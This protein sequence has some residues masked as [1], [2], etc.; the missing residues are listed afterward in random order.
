MTDKGGAGR[1]WSDTKMQGIL[2]LVQVQDVG[3][4]IINVRLSGTDPAGAERGIILEYELPTNF[5]FTADLTSTFSALQIQQGEFL[6]FLF[7]N[8]SDRQQFNNELFNIKKQLRLS[9]QQ[10]ADLKKK[11]KNKM[12]EEFSNQLADSI[13]VDELLSG[14]NIEV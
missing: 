7:T 2:K 5:S 6:G 13:Q 1:K 9:T 14:S 3:V 4:P 11:A 10:L 12:D 8:E